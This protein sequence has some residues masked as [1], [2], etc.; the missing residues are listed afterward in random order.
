M[1]DTEQELK[2]GT[3]LDQM[4]SAKLGYTWDEY[5]WINPTTG[6]NAYDSSWCHREGLR[7]PRYSTSMDDAMELVEHMKDKDFEIDLSWL[8]A[9]KKWEIGV[10]F[11]VEMVDKLH[12]GGVE[13]EADT[14]PMALCRAFLALPDLEEIE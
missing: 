9:E 11:P 7:Q 1:S 13:N 2:P 10:Y 5:R 8:P 14:A 4:I 6:F 12:Y 3:I